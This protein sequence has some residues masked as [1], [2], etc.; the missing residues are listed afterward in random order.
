MRVKNV[1]TNRIKVLV[2][3]F[4]GVIADSNKV[5]WGAYYRLFPSSKKTRKI[6]SQ[7]DRLN[8][9]RYEIIR[10]ILKALQEAGEIEF[11]D[12]EREMAERAKQYGE[13]VEKAILQDEGI[14]GAFKSLWELIDNYRLYLN[15]GTPQEPFCKVVNKLIESKKIPPLNGIFGRPSKIKE[16]ITA[17]QQNLLAIIKKENVTPKE[18]IFV[19]DSEIDRKV[20]ENI[21]C[22][23]IGVENEFSQWSA[24]NFPIIKNLRNLPRL[25]KKIEKGKAI[26]QK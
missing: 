12:I 1:K 2:F 15:S 19:G 13:I 24:Q 25:I 6:I 11:R 10:K 17:K 16:E 5:K 3:D 22:L 4:D 18:V 9:T 23:F 14:P 8:G 7:I 21:G 20:A 26:C